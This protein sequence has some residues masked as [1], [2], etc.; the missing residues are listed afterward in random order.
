L[1]HIRPIATA[2]DGIPALAVT[3]P[4]SVRLR[5][6]NPILI[7]APHFARLKEQQEQDAEAEA[8]LQGFDGLSLHGRGEPGCARRSG[9]RGAQAV[10]G[11]CFR[12]G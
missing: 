5:S 7:R 9:A 3:E 4:D 6:G 1:E 10:Q 8:D 11:F 2:L 12:I